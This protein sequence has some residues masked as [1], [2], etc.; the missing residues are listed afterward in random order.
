MGLFR[1]N[2]SDLNRL[3]WELLQNSNIN[4]YYKLDHFNSDIKWLE[5]NLYKVVVL[6][7]ADWKEN[8]DIDN[9]FLK[10]GVHYNN[11]SNLNGLY[12]CIDDL[13]F[14]NM[15]DGAIVLRDLD[16]FI[17]RFGKDYVDGFMDVLSNRARNYLL[18]G[19]RLVILAYSS[20]EIT[21][22]DKYGGLSM[23]RRD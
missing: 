15:S 1:I 10:L 6:K 12:D 7:C 11:C 17:E 14:P 23:L 22:F 20:K 2:T 9:Y 21:T 19:T 18:F 8:A 5:E 3:D 4:L 13:N 16:V